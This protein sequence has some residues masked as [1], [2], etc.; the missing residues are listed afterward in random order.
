[1]NRR[2]LLAAL[3]GAA[4]T[5]LPLVA[6]AQTVERTLKGLA[7]AKGL[8]Y[9]A[10]VA[11]WQSDR[12]AL[13]RR[14][15][16]RQCAA[17]VPEW[18]MKWGIIEGTR[19]QRNYSAPDRI[20]SFASSHRLAVRGHPAIWH[21]NLPRWVDGALK[22]EGE[23]VIV[24]HIRDL[25]THYKGK[26]TSWDIVNEAIE[27]KDGQPDS[28]RNSVF[29]RHL[30]PDYIARCFEIAAQADPGIQA[31]YNEYGLYHNDAPDTARRAAV[32]KLLAKLKSQGAPIYGLGI[33]GHLTVGRPFNP[34]TFA[35]FLREVAALGLKIMITELDI[36]DRRLTQTISERDRLVAE[37][38]TQF[39]T[40]A[41][42]ERAVEG[43]LTWGLSDKYSWLNSTTNQTRTDGTMNRCLPYDEKFDR[44]PFW[45]ALADAFNRA[46]RR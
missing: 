22:T 6:E 1:M 17:V 9:G 18:E 19:G 44:K 14:T 33:Q 26:I 25:L 27:P 46:P 35:S 3:P 28:L 4:M 8:L 40:V 2:Q 7:S 16:S 15:F 23:T 36:D 21:R 10:A 24:E 11:N 39:L 30:G 12:D 38:A 43:L 31:F 41:L 37:M 32:L 42:D 13:L 20:V 34:S 5:A 29:L 45:F